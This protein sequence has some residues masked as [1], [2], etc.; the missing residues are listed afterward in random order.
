LGQFIR[1]EMQAPSL[2]EVIRRR[3]SRAVETPEIQAAKIGSGAYVFAV[4]DCPEF[5][6]ILVEGLASEGLQRIFNGLS[7]GSV[8][9]GLRMACSIYASPHLDPK[10]VVAKLSPPAEIIKDLWR[11]SIPNYI[12][13]RSLVLRTSPM[14]NPANTWVGNVFGTAESRTHVGPFL[15]LLIL[16]FMRTLPETEIDLHVCTAQLHQLLR[17]GRSLIES[18]LRWLEKQNWIE[19]HVPHLTLTRRGRFICEEFIFHRDYL[20]QISTDVDMYPEA[21][22][23]LR[24]IPSTF[25]EQ[26]RNLSTLLKYLAEREL[27]MLAT[28]AENG[29][30]DYCDR[31]GSAGIT[32]QLASRIAENLIPLRPDPPIV[33][34]RELIKSVHDHG[35]LAGIREIFARYST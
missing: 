1:T 27:I 21:E 34:A 15:R 30:A 35:A 23:E 32:T 12:A 22:R 28:L 17:V 16:R 33:Q 29:L 14:Y 4:R 9:E 24:S 19:R 10:R 25:P 11:D 26:I 7:N 18:E 6:R 3:V 20:T 2:L 13:V 8:R 5:A 31:F